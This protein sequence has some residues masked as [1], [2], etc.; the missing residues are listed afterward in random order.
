MVKYSLIKVG[1]AYDQTKNQ[2]IRDF[3]KWFSCSLLLTKSS[4]MLTHFIDAPQAEPNSTIVLYYY[5]KY[6]PSMSSENLNL[7]FKN[8]NF[9]KLKSMTKF[10]LTQI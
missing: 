3:K 2:N 5:S 10:L 9:L 1:L 6:F 4:K 8:E 7:F